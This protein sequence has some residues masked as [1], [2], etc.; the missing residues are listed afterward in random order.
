MS[1]LP[2]A[3]IIAEILNGNEKVIS[4]VYKK[5]YRHIENYG[6][7]TNT[8]SHNIK[9]AV[10][11]AFEVFYR[12]ILSK[13]LVLICT[14]ETYIISIAKHCLLKNEHNIGLYNKEPINDDSLIDEVENEQNIIDQKHQLF[15]S[16]FKKLEPECQRVLSLTFQGKTSEEI[17]K[18]MK[19]SSAQFVRLKRK[20]CKGY[21]T[22]RIKENPEYERL[23][24]ASSEDYEFPLRRQE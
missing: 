14:V 18:L 5:V 24:D 1:K 2:G 23:K 8:N 10:Q 3:D 12:Q 13:K 15:V 19:Y 4:A 17:S 11:D 22:K 16:E 9:E 20:R 6:K 7:N 21:L